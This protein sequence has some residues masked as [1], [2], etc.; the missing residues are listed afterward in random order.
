MLRLLSR[1]THPKFFTTN[2]LAFRA[3][4]ISLLGQP[5][6]DFAGRLRYRLKIGIIFVVILRE[7]AAEFERFWTGQILFFA[8]F[9]KGI[10]TKFIKGVEAAFFRK[11]RFLTGAADKRILP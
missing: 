2:S 4:E 8:V 7:W 9:K 11:G 6:F 1:N 3:A 5:S 10:K